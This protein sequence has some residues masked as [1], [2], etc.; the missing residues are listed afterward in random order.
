M[1][2]EDFRAEGRALLARLLYDATN[3]QDR[4]ALLERYS[5]E[6]TRLYSNHAH[7]VLN[8]VFDDARTRLDARLSPDP[9]R[10]TVATV[11]TTV[12]D[13]WK[14]ITDPFAPRSGDDNTK[15]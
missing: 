8:G 7:D 4:N 10:A 5:D 15:E 3:E 13:F 9:V 12:Q 1:A 11:Q 6:L 2:I 14:A